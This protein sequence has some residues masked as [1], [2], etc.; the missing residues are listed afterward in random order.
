MHVADEFSEF[1]MI[2]TFNRKR[3]QTDCC[4]H[5]ALSKSLSPAGQELICCI[6]M[7]RLEWKITR[8]LA[9][10]G[11]YKTPVSSLVV[12][13]N[14]I[15][16]KWIQKVLR[17]VK[18]MLTTPASMAY[19]HH[20]SPMV[21][22][23]ICKQMSGNTTF[24]KDHGIN[25]HTFSYVG[26]VSGD[27]CGWSRRPADLLLRFHQESISCTDA[28]SRC[29]VQRR[30]DASHAVSPVFSDQASLEFAGSPWGW[31]RAACVVVQL[32]SAILLQPTIEQ[33]N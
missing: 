15:Y 3:F 32:K 22:D 18:T 8:T 24:F 2:R 1:S 14:E 30:L 19:V 11:L 13:E 27:P 6:S 31:I 9:M 23:M 7:F 17:L 4:P 10:A 5:K 29:R 16:I 12:V 20:I 25:H 21:L 28:L 26:S 33:T